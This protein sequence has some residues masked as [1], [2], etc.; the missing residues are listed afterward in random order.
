[1]LIIRVDQSLSESIWHIDCHFI[2]LEVFYLRNNIVIAIDPFD[3]NSYICKRVKQIGGKYTLLDD[4]DTFVPKGKIFLIG[5]NENN[6]VDSRDF[7]AIPY[8][9]VQYRVVFKVTLFKKEIT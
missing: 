4:E 9:L 5:D 8:G 7:G 2:K 6:S 1:M 3:H